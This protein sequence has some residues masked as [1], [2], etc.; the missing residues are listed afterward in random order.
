MDAE[1]HPEASKNIL[2]ILWS[3]SI[4]T[5]PG[6]ETQWAKARASSFKALAQFEVNLFF[7]PE[8]LLIYTNT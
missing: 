4:S 7:Y 5:H 6:L 8:W 3:V 2:Q 1:A